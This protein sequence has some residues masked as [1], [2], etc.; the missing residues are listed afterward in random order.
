MIQF[1][2]IIKLLTGGIEVLPTSNKQCVD[3]FHNRMGYP[4]I[5]RSIVT[6]RPSLGEKEIYQLALKL[7]DLG[8]TNPILDLSIVYRRLGKETGTIAE[9]WI[10][11]TKNFNSVK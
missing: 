2:R 4:V 3:Y 8:I 10:P 5:K 9:K 11:W 7:K 6:K 1:L